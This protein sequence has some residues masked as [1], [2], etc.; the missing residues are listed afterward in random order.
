V[1]A[2]AVKHWVA[3]VGAAVLILAVLWSARVADKEVPAELPAASESVRSDSTPARAPVSQEA[4]KTSIGR[5]AVLPETPQRLFL[6]STSP[7]RSVREGTAQIG[8]DP[9]HPQTYVGGAILA[10]GAQLTE[11]H[12]THVV[13]ERDGKKFELRVDGGK[14]KASSE[15]AM[16][17]GPTPLPSKVTTA[18]DRLSGVIRSMPVYN[19]DTLVGLQVFAGHRSGDFQQ[20]GLRNGDVIVAL[21][22]APVADTNDSLNLLRTLADGVAISATVRRQNTTTTV[23]LDGSLLAPRAQTASFSGAMTQ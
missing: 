7:G 17:G 2:P 5:D 19:G 4:P 9:K 12:P 3:F 11:I 15:L 22:G 16:V 21:D 1:Q 6:V 10:N 23:A 18:D 8:T 20:L 13:L 14:R